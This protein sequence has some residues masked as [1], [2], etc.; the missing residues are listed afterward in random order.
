MSNS[1]PFRRPLTKYVPN[2]KL[3]FLD[4]CEEVM[5]FKQLAGRTVETYGHWIERF[6]KFH[7]QP[8]VPA[9]QWIWRHPREMGHAEVRAFLTDLAVRRQV[10]VATQNQALNA[11]VFLYREVLGRELGAL[12]EF[13][14]PHRGSPTA[15]SSQSKP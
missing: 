5:R 15:S 1:E 9:G 11:L 14:R 10:A 3:K 4:Q 2:P 7:R 13:E 12:G 6:I 8:G